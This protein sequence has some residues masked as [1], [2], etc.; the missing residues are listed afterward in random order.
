MTYS[1]ERILLSS[2]REGQVSRFRAWVLLAI[3]LAAILFQV[4][5]PLFFQF[6][7]FLEM[8]L[9]VVVY[10]ALMRRNQITGLMVGAL[11]GLA[12]DSLSKNPLGMFGIVDTL[13]GYFAASVGLRLDV[14]HGFIRLLLVFFFFVFHQ[15]LY[16]VMVRALLGRPLPFEVQ[17]TLVVGVLNA[18]VGIS[19]FHFLD[20]LRER[21]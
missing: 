6:L 14:E 5:V 2:Q 9:L 10:F 12:Q 20:K 4:Y 15:F 1:G 8:P 13:V 19:L 7:R 18:L 3:P 17:Q 21:A 16:W 11:V